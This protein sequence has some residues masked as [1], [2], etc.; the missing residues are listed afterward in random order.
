MRKTSL[1]LILTLLVSSLCFSDKIVLR[2]GTYYYG[3]LKEYRFGYFYF[4]VK[5]VYGIKPMKFSKYDVERIEFVEEYI[6][7]ESREDEYIRE[8]KRGKRQKA[9]TVFSNK[10][11]LDTLIDVKEGDILFFEAKGTIRIG[12]GRPKIG[13]E[14]ELKKYWGDN[15]P[16]PGESTGALIG[17]IGESGAFLIGNERREFRM[18]ANGRLFLGVNDDNILD[19]SGYFTVVIFY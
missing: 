14:G 7:E 5:E 15:K 8:M 11:W 4:D 3:E 2:N 13:P 10:P 18:P 1:L 9:V 19:N 6:P 12:S 17:K 16:I